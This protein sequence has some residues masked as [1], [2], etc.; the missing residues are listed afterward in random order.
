[1]SVIRACPPEAT[2]QLDYF[3][4][5]TKKISV[6]GLHSEQL[7]MAYLRQQDNVG[8]GAVPIALIMLLTRPAVR[9]Y[10]KRPRA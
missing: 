8:I 4:I 2:H 7:L 6:V 1:V 10:F 5:G 9:A 3:Q